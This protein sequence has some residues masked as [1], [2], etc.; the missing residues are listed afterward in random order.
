MENLLDKFDP[1]NSGPVTIDLQALAQEL[2]ASSN[3]GVKKATPTVSIEEMRISGAQP[4]DEAGKKSGQLAQSNFKQVSLSPSNI[5]TFKLTYG[6]AGAVAPIAA[7][8]TQ[9]KPA[10]PPGTAP[11]IDLG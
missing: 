10:P 1:S 2:Y 11:G 6:V 8:A 5:R 7:A 3:P 4:L 9:S